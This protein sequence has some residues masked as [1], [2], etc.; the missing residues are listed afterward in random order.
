MLPCIVGIVAPT[1]GSITS[2][3]VATSLRLDLLMEVLSVCLV[4]EVAFHRLVVSCKVR[5]SLLLLLLSH[6]PRHTL[7][8]LLADLVGELLRC[9]LVDHY[10]VVLIDVVVHILLLVV[11][12]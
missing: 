8:G 9:A 10:E 5:L 3:A 2:V 7:L 12:L 1:V 4:H 6:F 11:L